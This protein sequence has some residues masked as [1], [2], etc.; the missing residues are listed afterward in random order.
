MTGLADALEE[1]L[2]N[3][4]RAAEC[5]KNIQRFAEQFEWNNALEPLLEFC[6]HPKRAGDVQ[7]VKSDELPQEMLGF[8]DPGFDLK[9][10]VKLAYDFM[11][12]GGPKLVATKV[13]SRLK[14]YIAR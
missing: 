11:K 2:F 8:I 10:D 1:L 14:K 9:R 7:F 12:T 6:R 3:E 4:Q 13:S 5:S